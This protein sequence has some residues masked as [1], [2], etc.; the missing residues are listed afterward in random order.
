MEQAGK[1]CSK[2]L[3]LFLIVFVALIVASCASAGRHEEKLKESLKAS[4]DTFNSA[5]KWEDYSDAVAFVPVAKKE[6][7]WA[8]VD[9]FKGK[10]RL[11]EYELREVS[12][13]E[14]VSSASAIVHFQYWRPEEPSLLSVTFTQKWYY[15]EKDKL[16]KVSDSGFGAITKTPARF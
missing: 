7:F 11:T 15:I 2:K 10:I 4:V 8:E 3:S 12:V 13:K 16:W 6:A 1:T 5:F 14:H 9:K